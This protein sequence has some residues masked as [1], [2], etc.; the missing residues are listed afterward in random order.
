MNVEKIGWDLNKFSMD[1]WSPETG[2][3]VINLKEL[4]TKHITYHN[5]WRRIQKIASTKKVVGRRLKEKYSK[6]EKNVCEQIV[7]DVTNVAKEIADIHKFEDLGKYGMFKKKGKKGGRNKKFN[8]WISYINWKSITDQTEYKADSIEY[9]DPYH[10]SKDCSR[11]GCTNKDL[12]GEKFECVN[13]DCGLVINRQPNAAISIYLKE[14]K[15]GTKN[16]S[17]DKLNMEGLSQDT[18]S[19]QKWFD[20]SVLR[21]FTQTGAECDYGKDIYGKDIYGKDVSMVTARKE[22]DELVRSLYDLMKPQFHVVKSRPKR[23]KEK[24]YLKYVH[25]LEAT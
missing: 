7:H 15:D 14:P 20:E 16:N 24:M 19:R 8:N 10:T 5:K 4:H 12:K 6:R 2:W 13:K 1:G 25:L 18:K 23:V 17:T 11:C 3:I 9:V 22:A 21:G